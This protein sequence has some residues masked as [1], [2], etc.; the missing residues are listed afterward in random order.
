MNET[1]RRI[2]V[3]AVL[4]PFQVKADQLSAVVP[5]RRAIDNLVGAVISMPHK[6]SIVSLLH[7]ITPTSKTVGAVNV[8]RREPDGRR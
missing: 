1:L 4:I 7:R 2:G 8:V 5:G 6:Q 3:D